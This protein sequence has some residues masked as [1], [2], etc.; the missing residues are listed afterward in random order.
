MQRVPVADE[1][2]PEAS[3][4]PVVDTEASDRGTVLTKEFLERIPPG[5][6]YQ[7]AVSVAGGIAGKPEKKKK[8]KETRRSRRDD[9]KVANQPAESVEMSGFVDIDIDMDM[10]DDFEY[11]AFEE[12]EE[13]EEEESDARYARIADAPEPVRAKRSGGKRGKKRDKDRA[14]LRADIDQPEITIMMGSDDELPDVKATSLDVIV[15]ANGAAVRYQR[16]LVPAG[17]PQSVRLEARRTRRK[18]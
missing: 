7:S 11:L 12:P 13:E 18:P 6:S 5:R 14:E 10:E 2:M 4:A 17:A 3:P 16:H 15:P 1:I 8:E 9:A